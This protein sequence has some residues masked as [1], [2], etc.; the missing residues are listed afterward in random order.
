MT[1]RRFCEVREGL[2]YTRFK[3][4][5]AKS[6]G[7][8]EGNDDRHYNFKKIG[9]RLDVSPLKVI[10]TYLQKHEMSFNHFVKTGIQSG[11]G[12][13]Q[14]IMDILNYYELAFALIEEEASEGYDEN[15]PGDVG[16]AEAEK[17]H[18]A[19]AR[20]DRG[21]ESDFCD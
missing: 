11:E 5:D 6:V 2:T 18:A 10:A 15:T 1:N 8:T 16:Y 4:C 21:E 9:E 12:V 3:M 13:A 17:L 7:Y 20:Q 19:E 14:T